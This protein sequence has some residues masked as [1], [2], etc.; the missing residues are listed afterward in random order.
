MVA[1]NIMTLSVI[2]AVII[3]VMRVRRNEDNSEIRDQL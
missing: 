3:G 2:G 1:A